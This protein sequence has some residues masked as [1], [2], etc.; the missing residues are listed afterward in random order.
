MESFVLYRI[1]SLVAGIALA[2]ALVISGCTTSRNFY[3]GEEDLAYNEE[4]SIFNT[5]MLP[6]VVLGVVVL[7]V[8][9]IAYDASQGGGSNYSGASQSRSNYSDVSC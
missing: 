2:L 1:R 5:V 7:G 4:F 9:A 8:V 6:V 3:T